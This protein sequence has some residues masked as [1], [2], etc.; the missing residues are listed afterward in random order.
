LSNPHP[1]PGLRPGAAVDVQE[2]PFKN[3]RWA[4]VKVVRGALR[5]AQGNAAVNLEV[6][7]FG[8]VGAQK[9][10]VARGTVATP[11][12]RRSMRAET[13][14]F[15]GSSQRSVTIFRGVAIQEFMADL[16]APAKDGELDRVAFAVDSIES[17]HGADP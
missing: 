1:F 11:E 3:P 14:N 7:S 15:T 5:V 9:V 4:P 2:V 8:K 17:R 12:P 10:T 13:I 16:F 6:L